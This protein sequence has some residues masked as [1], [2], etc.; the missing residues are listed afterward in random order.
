VSRRARRRA[1][2]AEACVARAARDSAATRRWAN[3][4]AMRARA[5]RAAATAR[6]SVCPT[7]CRA[8]L[9]AERLGEAAARAGAVGPAAR[10]ASA[11]ATKLHARTVAVKTM[12]A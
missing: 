12:R 5:R 3:A 8:E 6:G 4:C 1:V 7:Q 9:A 10:R 11:S 2:P